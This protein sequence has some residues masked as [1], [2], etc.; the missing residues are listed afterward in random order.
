[1]PPGPLFKVGPDRTDPAWGGNEER[2]RE[3]VGDT[4]M[5][6]CPHCQFLVVD[7]ATV[8]N[9]C[10]QPMTV[11]QQPAGPWG[12]DPGP[13][14]SGTPP[15]PGTPNDPGAPAGF[16]VPAARSGPSGTKV[17]AIVIGCLSLLAVVSVAAVFFIGTTAVETVATAPAPADWKVYRDPTARFQVDLPGTPIKNT[18]GTPLGGGKEVRVD[19]LDV[20]RGPWDS[21]MFVIDV[22]D[23]AQVEIPLSAMQEDLAQ[24]IQSNAGVS[25]YRVTKA[26]SVTA[27][28]GPAL[29][30]HFT[31]RLNGVRCVGLA[32][33]VRIGTDPYGVLSVGPAGRSGQ[34]SG[35]FDRMVGSLQVPGTT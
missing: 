6:T 10:K 25:D 29:E 22:P 14:F 27:P 26:V 9:V 8:C 5:K 33:F 11:P 20:S 12:A 28:S 17:A 23:G 34:V 4:T 31:V 1:L 32:H 30:V 15:V 2:I 16:V 3:N 35:T 18:H 7:D 21:A 24:T 13:G 19:N